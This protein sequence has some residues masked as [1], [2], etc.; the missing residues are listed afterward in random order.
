MLNQRVVITGR[1]AVSPYG[2]GLKNLID[3]IWQGRSAVVTMEDW[4]EIAGLTSHL[5]APV[6]AYNVKKALPRPLRRTMGAMAINGT[7]ASMEA[8]KNA[9]L[10]EDFLQSG[11]VGVAF[12]STTGS[13]E[14]YEKLY[15]IFLF[16]KTIEPVKSGEFF[17]I[18]G[19]SC[20]ANIM[21]A[22]GLKGEQWAPTSACTSSAQ[23]IGLGYLLIATGR[24]KA[25]I[26]GG[27]EDVHHSVTTTFDVLRAT[28]RKNDSPQTTPSPFD[29]DRDGVVCG[30]G[31]G[32]LLLE[33]LDSAQKRGAAI[34]AEIVG[35]GHVSDPGHIAHPD[36]KAMAEAMKKALKEADIPP[37]SIDYIN[38]HAT[39]TPQGD[40][41]EAEAIAS[42]VGSK[43]PVS[44]CKGH[45][46]HTLSAA[47][48]LESIL[49]LEM[50][51]RSEILPTL[52]LINPDTECTKVELP[53]KLTPRTI[54]YIMK[55]NFAMGGVNTALIYKNW[56]KK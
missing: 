19:H 56:T 40:T 42:V 15:K 48:A 9:G 47:G 7:L 5:A 38:A 52:N 51:Q 44:S 46:G 29:R 3:N 25:M 32:S 35:F 17:K 55:N 30:A 39:G 45:M 49:C 27:A 31:A 16:E 1:G 11:E 28:S 54:K 20:S 10:S 37:D 50:M 2:I 8:I 26:C 22:L 23:A 6:P 41:A 18:M 14:I 24:Q 13:P 43:V 12:G 21:Y 33:S 36:P 53:Q 34:L 4:R